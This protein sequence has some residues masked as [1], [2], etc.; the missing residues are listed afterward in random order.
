MNL[1]KIPKQKLFIFLAI[2]CAAF[3]RIRRLHYSIL[4]FDDV[5]TLYRN[6]TRP[7]SSPAIRAV[8]NG[9]AKQALTIVATNTR[10]NGPPGENSSICSTLLHSASTI[11]AVYYLQSSCNDANIGNKLSRV[12]NTHAMARAMKLPFHFICPVHKEKQYEHSILSKLALESMTSSFNDTMV[13]P[14]ENTLESI[15]AACDTQHPHQCPSG[16]LNLMVEKIRQDLYQIGTQ[17]PDEGGDAF[18]VALHYRCGDILGISA[19]KYGLLP[20]STYANLIESRHT[21]NDYFTVAM[22]SNFESRSSTNDLIRLRDAPFDLKCR[23]LVQD[24]AGFLT[25]RFPKANISIPSSQSIAQDYGRLI[26]AK[27]M[28]ICGPSTFCLWPT[29]A[30]ANPFIYKSRLFPWVEQLDSQVF[31]VYNSPRLKPRANQTL[32]GLGME[33][34]LSWLQNH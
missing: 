33:E 25:A 1:S 15:C 23:L 16:G 17:N 12:Y 32:D 4:S 3:A 8:S 9:L 21:T 6:S 20:H 10:A 19:D 5:D 14:K 27:S 13:L 11:D 7:G 31:T 2:S 29:L 18:D 28:A 22:L 26:R 24:L 30:N 34:I